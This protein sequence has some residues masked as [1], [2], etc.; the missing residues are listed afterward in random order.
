MEGLFLKGLEFVQKNKHTP[1]AL[2]IIY[3]IVWYIYDLMFDKFKPHII[4]VT[5]SL[6]LNC[7]T[8]Y[9]YLVILALLFVIIFYFWYKM[10]SI[11]RFS[12][13]QLG[14]IFAPNFDPELEK[15][16]QKIER[17][18]KK[19]IKK[20]D[21]E[22]K[23]IIKRLPCNIPI[24]SKVEAGKILKRSKASVVI[25]CNINK[26]KKGDDK[27][28]GFPQISFT[29]SGP[30]TEMAKK[31]LIGSNVGMQATMND[32]T[33]IVDV[34]NM[35]V[36]IGLITRNI[37]AIKFMSCTRWR[38]A[39]TFFETLY[40]DY[41]LRLRSR[42]NV[43]FKNATNNV[44]YCLAFSLSMLRGH[45]YQ[46][47]QKNK[48]FLSIPKKCLEQWISDANRSIKLD[49]TNALHYIYKG[50]FLFLA[51][52]VLGAIDA[53]LKASKNAI[54]NENF[55][56]SNLSLGFLYTFQGN[57]T[58]FLEYYN[59]AFCPS[60]HCSQNLIV[61]CIN[62]TKLIIENFSQKKQILMALVILELERGNKKQSYNLLKE[63]IESSSDDPCL[64]D[65]IIKAKKL[66]YLFEEKNYLTS[67]KKIPW[68]NSLIFT[69]QKN[70]KKRKKKK[71]KKNK[72]S[73]K[74]KKKR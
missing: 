34:N 13:K 58:K 54:N 49:P 47:Y 73:K 65:F 20:C 66:L 3:V 56:N 26:E 30:G 67:D 60:R 72:K 39:V 41:K 59:N 57:C 50:L 23:F 9:N 7:H 24:Y 2:V 19:E 32:S 52:D 6:S 36:D 45:E 27:V 11:P 15:D 46:K 48:Q 22:I 8:S 51:G 69:T 68:R 74:S 18:L 42:N 16:I 35:G 37:I 63:F 21:G 64:K 14:V 25:W 70:Q 43:H 5:E 33:L 29:W 44:G 12:K 10:R 71:N 38:D 4:N 62:F 1:T 61:T 31:I 55:C 28:I 17:A 40:E 53:E